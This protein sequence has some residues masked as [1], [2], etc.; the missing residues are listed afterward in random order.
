MAL[1]RLNKADIRNVAVNRK[2]WF[3]SGLS[4][5]NLLV[6]ENYKSP[7]SKNSPDNNDLGKHIH[8]DKKKKMYLK[9]RVV[10]FLRE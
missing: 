10:C 9:K 3:G 7:A 6:H 1:R 4:I 2:D 8:C 5:S